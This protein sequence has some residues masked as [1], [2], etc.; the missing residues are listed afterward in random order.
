MLLAITTRF[1]SRNDSSGRT[2]ISLNHEA[3]GS[4]SHW[5]PSNQLDWRNFDI[6]LYII[7]CRYTDRAD[8]LGPGAVSPMQVKSIEG[9][10][11]DTETNETGEGWFCRLLEDSLVVGKNDTNYDGEF[12]A[13]CEATLAAGQASAKI[14][15][16]IDSQT[17]ILVFSSNTPTECVN[18]IQCRTKIA[19]LISYDC[20]V[21]LQWV[22]SHVGIQSNERVN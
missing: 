8:V 19:E 14:V 4:L 7:M 20:N 15:F 11:A 3:S 10:I 22:P 6:L 17:V 16:F 21:A 5:E 13:V 2:N 9:Q 18:I 1:F 12:L